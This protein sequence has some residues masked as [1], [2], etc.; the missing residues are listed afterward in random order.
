MSITF[1]NNA[2][3][4]A[5]SFLFF[6]LLLVSAFGRTGA[7]SS[8]SDGMLLHAGVNSFLGHAGRNTCDKCSINLKFRV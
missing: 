5:I 8:V 3:S 1:A 7:F 4:F 6:F 2:K